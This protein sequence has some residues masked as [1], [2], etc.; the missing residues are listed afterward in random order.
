VDLN[1]PK[2]IVK[3]RT[4]IR[5]IQRLINRTNAPDDFL[6]KLLMIQWIGGRG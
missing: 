1:R 2:N 6:R 5:D 4:Q 3:M